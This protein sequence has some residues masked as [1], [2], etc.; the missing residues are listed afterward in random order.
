MRTK[1]TES[2]AKEKFE[3]LF[4]SSKLISFCRRKD[5][6]LMYE[7]TCE[8]NHKITKISVSGAISKQ[9]LHCKQ[10][11]TDKSKLSIDTVRTILSTHGFT[12]LSKEYISNRSKLKV[13]C[14]NGCEIYSSFDNLIDRK[15]NIARCWN[16]N[17]LLYEKAV[18]HCF[19]ELFGIPFKKDRYDFLKLNGFN[20]ELD[21]YATINNQVIAFEYN[22][23][24]HYKKVFPNQDLES[25]QKRDLWKINQCNILGIKLIVLSY[26]EISSFKDI[27]PV[28]LNKCK[29]QNIIVNNKILNIDYSKLNSNNE[30]LVKT[31]KI[32]EDK[33][34]RM[35]SDVWQ[36]F[37]TKVK[38]EC[39]VCKYVWKTRPNGIVF[40]NNNCPRCFGSVVLS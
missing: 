6:S 38:F 16:C 25:Q 12:L 17:K 20:L 30:Y 1:W 7:Y 18:R 4:A 40:K 11:A 35:C 2:T 15:N 13:L 31:Q 39:N 8:F 19:Q 33:N 21:G 36:G 23:K 14:K 22:G 10:C 24:Q 37:N 28:V 9:K 27:L 32:C 5:G 34:I 3:E 26:K 29:Q